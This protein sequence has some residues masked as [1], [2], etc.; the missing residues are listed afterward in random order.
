VFLKQKISFDNDYNEMAILYFFKREGKDPIDKGI[1]MGV[2]YR[3]FTLPLEIKNCGPPVYVD[4]QKIRSYML[5]WGYDSMV[6]NALSNQKKGLDTWMDFQMSVGA[7]MTDLDDSVVKR[8]QTANPYYTD[9]ETDLICAMVDM[10]ANIGLSCQ[11]R[12][13]LLNF[14]IGAGL[15]GGLQ[16]FSATGY[17]DKEDY[18][19][20]KPEMSGG[21][22]HYGP[23]V[24]GLVFW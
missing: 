24:K 18:T 16:T 15:T 10:T 22:W 19:R 4:A 3:S 12:I 8:I 17:S 11:W 2:S 7:G 20:F 14:N 13:G 5:T 9:I 6:A 21:V 23:V 1:Y